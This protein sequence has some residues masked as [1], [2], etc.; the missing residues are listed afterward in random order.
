MKWRWA[1]LSAGLALLAA[2]L[3]L[4]LRVALSAADLQRA[5][6]SARQ[7]G[8]TVWRGRIEELMLGRQL[9]GTFGVR[10]EPGA[11]LLG[12]VAMPFER[13]DGDHGPLTGM[14]RAGGSVTGVE[15]LSGSLPTSNLFGPAPIDALTFDQATILFEGER[16]SRASGQVAANLAV[17]LGPLAFDRG[18]SG[19]IACAGDRV[20]A[21]LVSD[22]GTEQIEFFLSASGQLRG[23]V[24]IRSPLPGFDALLLT[25]GFETSPGGL[26]LPFET[27]L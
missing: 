7:L 4:P 5:G 8:G 26:V 17:R 6:M 15:R 20:R 12:R 23:A 1:F 19:P 9:L 13:L 10:L 24:T 14:L 3:L 18:F 11:L 2:M 27:R 25:Y 21:R 22:G 16:C